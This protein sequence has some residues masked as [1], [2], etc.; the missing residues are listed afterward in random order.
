MRP[1]LFACPALDILLIQAAPPQAKSFSADKWNRCN[2]IPPTD[3]FC[4]TISP[5]SSPS[6]PN[7]TN[8]PRRCA[9]GSCTPSRPPTSDTTGNK[10]LSQEE[11]RTVE[12]L[13]RRD[14]E[15]RAHEQAHSAAAGGYA[16]GGASYQYQPGPDGKRYA[17]GGE[18]S[19]DT[20]AVS[21]DPQ[22][23]IRKMQVVRKAALAPAQP[24]AQDRS[25]AATA[26]QQMSQARQELARQRSEA[27]PSPGK[28]QSSGY[29]AKAQPLSASELAATF[30]DICG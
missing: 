1:A 8:A 5:C 13:K 29:S 22:A 18:V 12:E 23:T 21:D 24:S 17:V 3:T 20:S 30:L 10:P 7:G 25:V 16:R 4:M 15:V 6:C 19:I 27:P 11:Q 26:S 9:G 2:F 28:N 14:Q